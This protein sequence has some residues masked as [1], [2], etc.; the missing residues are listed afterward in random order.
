MEGVDGYHQDPTAA[1][2]LMADGRL[3]VHLQDISFRDCRLYSTG[4]PSA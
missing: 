4:C 3:G 2:L 1:A